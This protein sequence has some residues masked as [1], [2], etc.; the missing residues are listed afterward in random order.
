MPEELVRSFDE[1][2]L[3]EEWKMLHDALFFRLK[4]AKVNE[5]VT[6]ADDEDLFSGKVRVEQLSGI[7]ELFY[8]P[9][10]YA[11]HLRNII[12]L[13]EEYPAFRFYALPETPFPNMKLMIAGDMTGIVHA[14]RPELSFGFNH[15]LM[16]RAFQSYARTLMEQYR[17]DRNTLRKMLEGKCL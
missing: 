4:K 15:P 2:R 6:L 5:C 11:Q 17:M 14:K 8:T 7:R 12:R 9:E 10:K 16:C 13:S 1:P 3:Y